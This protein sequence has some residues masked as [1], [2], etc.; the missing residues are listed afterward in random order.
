MR[1]RITALIVIT[2][3]GLM[4]I[5]TSSVAQAQADYTKVCEGTKQLD[6]PFPSTDPCDGVVGIWVGVQLW[7]DSSDGLNYGVNGEKQFGGDTR[8]ENMLNDAKAYTGGSAWFRPGDSEVA[9][10]ATD[11]STTTVKSMV[12]RVNLAL[13]KVAEETEPP[14]WTEGVCSGSSAIVYQS[15][16]RTGDGVTV[17]VDDPVGCQKDG[18]WYVVEPWGPDNMN[19]DAGCLAKLWSSDVES[20]LST[21]RSLAKRN[22]WPNGSAWMVDAS[23]AENPLVVDCATVSGPNDLG[24]NRYEDQVKLARL[25][26]VVARAE[27]L[28]KIA[29]MTWDDYCTRFGEEPLGEQVL[30]SDYIRIK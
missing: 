24:L 9:M 26:W 17:S 19:P 25:P 14:A 21:V 7:S 10:P 5:V 29:K 12:G 28:L 3:V 22:N 4:T 8:Y 16:K 15:V 23:Y 6:W 1:S 2:L 30:C 27:E 13:A 18:Y 20:E 11:V